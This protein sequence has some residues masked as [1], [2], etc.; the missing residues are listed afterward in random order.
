V[1]SLPDRTA[2]AA[3]ATNYETIASKTPAPLKKLAANYIMNELL[4]NL[5]IKRW[6][7]P[8]SFF[9]KNRW[10]TADTIILADLFKHQKDQMG[11]YLLNTQR[12]LINTLKKVKSCWQGKDPWFGSKNSMLYLEMMETFSQVIRAEPMT[13][14]MRFLL[15]LVFSREATIPG[16]V[17]LDRSKWERECHKPDLVFNRRS[18]VIL[19]KVLDELKPF[20]FLEE[21]DTS[22]VEF[23]NPEP[24][25][26]IMKNAN[27]LKAVKVFCG[28]KA[29]S[30][31]LESVHKYAN[32]ADTIKIYGKIK[33]DDL[34]SAFFGGMED[35]ATVLSN[36]DSSIKLSFPLLTNVLLKVEIEPPSNSAIR[37]FLHVLTHLYPN[38]Q[39][40]D[41]DD[42]G[43]FITDNR[44]ELIEAFG[45]VTRIPR[46]LT[47][48]IICTID[49]E[50]NTELARLYPK[51][52]NLS[53]HMAENQYSPMML[54]DLVERFTLTGLNIR[55]FGDH[56]IYLPTFNVIGSSLRELGIT[57]DDV[58]I[59]CEILNKCER[60]ECLRLVV[61]KYDQVVTTE[62]KTLHTLNTLDLFYYS[63]L[64]EPT[65]PPE[66]IQRIL[67]ASPNVV[68]L[69]LELGDKGLSFPWWRQTKILKN[70]EK[71][72]LPVDF[73]MSE[74]IVHEYKEAITLLVE[75]LPSLSL[76]EIWA[77]EVDLQVFRYLKN[78][79]RHTMLEVTRELFK[80]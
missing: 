2:S 61:H 63:T 75:G 52:D 29:G 39:E 43:T 32:Q 6:P 8:K 73:T 10:I 40:A 31:L 55:S 4:D 41:C 9:H 27:N 79:Y 64:K 71:L 72:T 69:V 54:K 1:V 13:P 53:I 46:G 44:P 28:L 78:Y 18:C 38:I 68:H 20:N 62:I 23:D 24:V 15:S 59:V 12:W 77:R 17:E 7:K 51:C 47:K 35:K 30:I 80:E 16:G 50:T 19:A 5:R 60:L 37:T 57:A 70:V 36:L 11:L 56:F 67:V 33:E 65:P 25:E 3:A 42:R 58:Q 22:L 48:L 21:L 66:I 26:V 76:L 34:Y 14:L 45:S 74:S 49:Q